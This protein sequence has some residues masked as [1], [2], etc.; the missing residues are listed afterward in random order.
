[1][2][3]LWCCDIDSCD[4]WVL[5]GV[6]CWFCGWD[7]CGAWLADGLFYGIRVDLLLLLVSWL[8]CVI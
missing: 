1:M 2:C 5:C 4:V 7:V 3:A 6:R 8:S